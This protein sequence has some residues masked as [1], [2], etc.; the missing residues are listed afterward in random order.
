M[1]DAWLHAGGRAALLM[2][3]SRLASMLIGLL[4]LPILFSCLGAPSFAAWALLM[5]FATGCSLLEFGMPRTLVRFLARALRDADVEAARTVT[6][7]A[8]ALLMVCFGTGGALVV[9]AAG[10]IAEWLDLPAVG[11]VTASGAAIAVFLAV[12]VRAFL[13][14]GTLS[15]IAERRFRAVSAVSIAQPLAANAAAILSALAW[16][17]LDAVLLAFWLAQLTVA[18]IVFFWQRRVCLPRLERDCFRPSAMGEMFR[19]G[20]AHQLEGWAQFANFELNKFLIAGVVGLAEVPAYE[21]ASRAALALRSV[22][23]TGAESFLPIATFAHG[24]RA[25]AWI[26]YRKTTRL[27]VY[28]VIIFLLAPLAAAPL[29]MPA[30]VGH[31]GYEAHWVFAALVA[32]AAC[33]VLA[34][35][36]VT[37]AQVDGRPASIGLAAVVAAALN[38]TLSAVLVPQ[39]GSS[40]AALGTALALAIGAGVLVFGVHRHFGRPIRPTLAM[41]AR[42]GPAVSMC[43]LWAAATHFLVL[44]VLTSMGVSRLGLG[45]GAAAVFAACVGCVAVVEW[46]WGALGAAEQRKLNT[47]L[48]SSMRV[49]V[50]WRWRHSPW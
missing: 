14:A 10:P 2:V 12:G 47:W 42:F 28:A 39:F 27:T 43:L 17:R 16:S 50:Q 23:A 33:N 21:I 31:V 49:R 4:T 26:W 8:W 44:P 45:F 46:H 20:F 40:G 3:G 37:L 18:G 22:P 7:R 1:A 5:A 34:L 15:L 48:R 32:G 25:R 38:V 11:S 30:W 6:G 9:T 36:A 35:P 29:F 24:S 13:Q 41:L 19:W